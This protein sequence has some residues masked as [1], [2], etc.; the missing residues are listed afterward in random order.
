MN[1]RLKHPG[2]NVKVNGTGMMV[3]KV[4]GSVARAGICVLKRVL[5][6]LSHSKTPLLIVPGGWIF[7]DFVRLVDCSHNLG[8]TAHDMAIAGMEIYAMLISHIG[9][10]DRITFDRITLEELDE[11]SFKGIYV[12]MPYSSRIQESE[13]PKSWDVTSDSIAIWVASKLKDWGLG[14][15]TVLK[16]TDVDGVYRNGRF[17]ERVRARDALG[18]IDRYSIRLIEERGIDVFVC[19]GLKAGRVKGYIVEGKTLG[20]LIER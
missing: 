6:E 20:T 9:G 15:K 2:I 10:F 8:E 12:L 3:V 5:E 17:C 14:G 19:N 16:I 1:K 7:A 18:C 4:G 11:K 13:L